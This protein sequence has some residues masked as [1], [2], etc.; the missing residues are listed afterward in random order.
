MKYTVTVNGSEIVVD[1]DGENVRLDGAS[2]RV[3]LAEAD[4]SPERILTVGDDVHRVFVRPGDTR[5]RYTLWVDG[6]RFEVEALDERSRAIRE[7]SA[8]TEFL[9][10]SSNQPATALIELCLAMFN[11]N[12]FIY[13]D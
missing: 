12:E 2:A 13:V 1:L 7:L 9:R 5:G 11:L 3:R 10:T 6:F 4:G 8:A